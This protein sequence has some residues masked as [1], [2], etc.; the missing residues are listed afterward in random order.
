MIIAFITYRFRDAPDSLLFML[1]HARIVLEDGVSCVS[2]RI[3][4]IA[5]RR[6]FVS[7][8]T[9]L[10]FYD[11]G[12]RGGLF[13]VA[14]TRMNVRIRKELFT[15]L[16]HQ[17]IGFF[18]TTKTGDITSRLS[19]DTTSVSDSV[20]LNLNVMLRSITQAA[21]VLAFMFSASWRLTVVTFIMVP[22]VLA[23]CKTYGAYYRQLSK[24]VQA[25]LAEANA[26]A[27]EALGTMTT[28]KAHAAE[29][30]VEA[31]YSQKLSKFYGLQLKEALAYAIYMTTNTFLSSAVVAVVLWYG[32]TLVLTKRMSSGSLV[33]FL[34]YQQSLSAAFQALGDVFSALSAA[35]G[36]ADKVVE[37]MQRR[38]AFD[39]GGR[40]VPAAFFGRIELRD[41]EF[42]YPARPMTKILNDFSLIIEP[43]EVVALVGALS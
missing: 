42:S 18:D 27:E 40:L 4:G 35:V 30:S 39:L 25:E 2:A 38:P 26:V 31:S 17:T 32:G 33:S 5:D 36:A 3:R 9:F 10:P 7:V 1:M 14:M 41:V 19:A 13:T 29:G 24:K 15:S 43:G 11:A 12:A 37:L 34:L 21:M 20:C 16:L 23:I 6:L 22:I 28:V 8:K